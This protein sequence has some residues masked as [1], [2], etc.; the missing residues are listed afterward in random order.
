MTITFKLILLVLAIVFF[1]LDAF[2][3]QANV[4]WVSLGFACVTASLIV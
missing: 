3:V 1:L 4:N 2:R